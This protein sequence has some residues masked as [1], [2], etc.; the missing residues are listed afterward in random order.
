VPFV[1]KPC[2]EDNSLGVTLVHDE[3]EVLKVIKCAFS[4]DSRVH[5]EDFIAGREIWAACIENVDGLLTVLPTIK[6]RV[7]DIWTSAHKLQTGLDGKLTT[8]P[9]TAVMREGHCQCPADLSPK[10]HERI[11]GMVNTAHRVLECRLFC[12]FSPLSVICAMAAH[13]GC[14]DL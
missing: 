7:E 8:K 6:Y 5:M 3:D 11:D 4:F 12:F 13:A 2:T 10:L 14:E 1:V 9:I